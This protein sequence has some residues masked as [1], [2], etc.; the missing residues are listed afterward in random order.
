MRSLRELVDEVKQE[1]EKRSKKKAA[2][3]KRPRGGNG[4]SPTS[5]SKGDRPTAALSTPVTLADTKEQRWRLFAHS[6]IF[7]NQ[8]AKIPPFNATQA[9]QH[10]YGVSKKVANTNGP[11]LLVNAGFRE[12][13]AEVAK[14]AWTRKGIDENAVAQAWLGIYSADLTDY[15]DEKGRISIADIKKLPKPLRQN[16][17]KL[18]TKV[19]TTRRNGCQREEVTVAIELVDRVSVLRDLARWRGMF[20]EEEANEMNKVADLIAAGQERLRQAARTFNNET[21]EET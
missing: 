18:T 2:K 13:L 20:A 14:E 10:V 21:G 17:K 1:P 3:K 15:Y 12:I 19:T 16:I 8:E 6:Y 9:Y 4:A 7:G 11:R 5:P